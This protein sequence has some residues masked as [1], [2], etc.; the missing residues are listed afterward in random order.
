MSSVRYLQ[1]SSASRDRRFLRISL[2]ILTSLFRKLPTYVIVYCKHYL[3]DR[4]SFLQTFFLS[5]SSRPRA[6]NQSSIFL[7]FLVHRTTDF[8]FILIFIFF[9]QKIYI[10]Q[11]H[12]VFSG[13]SA[14]KEHGF[15]LFFFLLGFFDGRLM[16][17]IRDN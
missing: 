12:V 2:H 5:A 1:F 15:L 11:L 7:T 3:T 9:L 17:F 4:F 10:M 13:N 8:F 6:S 16:M 14:H